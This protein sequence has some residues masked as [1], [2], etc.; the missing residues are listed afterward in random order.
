MRK[1]SATVGSMT[2]VDAHM[3]RFVW[4]PVSLPKMVRPYWMRRMSSLLVTTMGQMSE[5]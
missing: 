5:L 4:T 3:S 2:M 1:Y